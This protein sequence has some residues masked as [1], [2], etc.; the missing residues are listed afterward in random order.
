MSSKK[1]RDEPSIE[2]VKARTSIVAL[3]SRDITLTKRG[4]DHW[5]CCPFHAEKSASFKVSEERREFRCFGCGTHGDALDY[6]RRVHGMRLPE[7]LEH[8]AIEAGLCPD[9]EGRRR[10]TRQPIA[11]PAAHG[12]SSCQDNPNGDPGSRRTDP[13]LIRP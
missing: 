12:G 11:P 13:W 7:A 10:P 1:E 4:R 9:R 3:V 8:L 2:D 5:A 6:L